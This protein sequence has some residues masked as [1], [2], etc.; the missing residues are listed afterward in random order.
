MPNSSNITGPGAQLNQLANEQQLRNAVQVEVRGWQGGSKDDVVAFISR[1]TR[2]TLMSSSIENDAVVGYVKTQNDANQLKSWNGVRFAGNALE[3]KVRSTATSSTI[4]ML[5]AFLHRRYNQQ[6][7]MLDLS[8]I[9]SDTQLQSQGAFSSMTTQSKMF[10]ALMKLA[11]Q[12]K[13]I[14]ES[15]NLS[16]NNLQ[17][18]S[19][20]SSLAQTFPHLVNLALSNNAISR[21]KA[22]EIWKHKFKALRELVMANNPITSN[23]L[24]K[25]EVSKVFPRLVILDGVV[26]RDEAKLK[27]IYE[28]P[29]PHKQFFFED[30]EIQQL[31]TQ[32]I[33]NFLQCWDNDR[34]QL[35]PLYTPDSQFSLSADSSVPND[36]QASDV[37]FGLYLPLSRNISRVSNTRSREQRLGKGQEQ[38]YKLFQQLPKTKHKLDTDPQLYSVEAWRYPQVNGFLVSLHGEDQE[39][40]QPEVHPDQ[41]NG[42]NRNRNYRRNVGGSSSNNKLTPKSFDRVFTIVPGPGSLIIASDMLIVRPLANAK[43]WSEQEM[44]P[45]QQPSQPQSNTTSTQ[46][47][48]QPGV[49]LP[50]NLTPQQGQMVERLMMETKLNLQF[51]L[52]LS[53]Q[54]GWN[55]ENA[56]RGF[57]ESHQNGQVPPEAFQ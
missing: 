22:L 16:D 55:Y 27:A 37:S 18:L 8:N 6:L 56:L 24:Y 14:V 35:M 51:T 15:V 38:I 41:N 49:Q 11:S 12:E 25:D 26:I 30:A 52:L 10:P 34:S 45:Q 13:F 39:V 54:A 5:K 4:E 1:K 7:K 47:T 31:S 48:P 32:F 50:P 44:Q 20:I 42:S 53:E 29:L 33:S 23:P 40:A 9:A 19:G 21:L 57:T 17:D 2:I 46:G 3:F 43:A 36:A 28:L